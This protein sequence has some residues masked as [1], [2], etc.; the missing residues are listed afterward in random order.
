MKKKLAYDG[1][2]LE[3][4]RKRY[5]FQAVFVTTL[6]LVALYFLIMSSL[7]KGILFLIC[8]VIVFL[9]V[10]MLRE[11]RESLQTRG[12]GIILANK[13]LIFDNLDF[14]YGMPIEEENLLPDH[15]EY[16]RKESFSSIRGKNFRLQ[17]VMLFNLI[18]SKFIELKSVTFHGVFFV[19]SCSSAELKLKE[20]NITAE[21]NDLKRLLKADSYQIFSDENKVCFCF[22]TKFPL[23]YQF[24]LRKINAVSAFINHIEKLQ[25]SAENV[26]EKLSVN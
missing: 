11:L 7:D 17:E 1:K 14:D 8:L 12:E 25:I 22:K 15:W 10:L 5:L 24:T 20:A 13:N 21:L 16:N 26:V 19:V 2:V 18:S 4:W 23:F 9:A 3:F 6:A